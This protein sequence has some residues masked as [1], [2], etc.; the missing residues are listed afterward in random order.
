MKP[1]RN[2]L[3]MELRLA[4]VTIQ[5]TISLPFATTAIASATEVEVDQR[6]RPCDR[7]PEDVET[8]C[9]EPW[10]RAATILSS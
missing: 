4:K 9:L 8:M 7:R 6:L 2:Q 10:L 3:R 5:L 1:A